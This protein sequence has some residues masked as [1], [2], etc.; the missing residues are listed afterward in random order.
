MP[1]FPLVAL[2]V[3]KNKEKEKE[4]KEGKKRGMNTQQR[5]EGKLLI[6]SYDL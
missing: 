5:K 6:I 3:C 1:L 2:L 4:K